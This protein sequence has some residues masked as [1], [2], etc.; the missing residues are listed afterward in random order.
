ME[1]THIALIFC[2]YLTL[3]AFL[4]KA[5]LFHSKNEKLHNLGTFANQFHQQRK[6]Y[7]SETSFFYSF[8]S[9]ILILQLFL[10]G[11]VLF[12]SSFFLFST[13]LKL[14]II[15][16]T[17]IKLVNK[18]NTII[19]VHMYVSIAMTLYLFE[20]KRTIYKWKEPFLKGLWNFPVALYPR[21]ILHI[22]GDYYILL[23]FIFLPKKNIHPFL[24]LFTSLR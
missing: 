24:Y 1:L 22:F 21:E 6:K 23:G 7:F 10:E 16:S 3:K 19:G 12:F 20:C 11:P 5:K 15:T 13:L 18:S 4:F 14:T 2:S 8:K 17:Y 9:S